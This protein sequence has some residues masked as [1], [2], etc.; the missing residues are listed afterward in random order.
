MRG[1]P[2]ASV[3]EATPLPASASSYILPASFRETYRPPPMT[4]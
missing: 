4:I 2:G 3:A 1:V